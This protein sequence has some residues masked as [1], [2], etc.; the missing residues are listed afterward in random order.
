[1][2][3]INRED[4]EYQVNLPYPEPQVEGRNRQYA[5]TLLRDYAGR[6]SELTAMLQYT[7]NSY[8]LKERNPEIAEIMKEI[9]E[10][11]KIHLDLLG[12]TILLLGLRPIYGSPRRYWS[13]NNVSYDLSLKEILENCIALETELIQNYRQQK[14]QIRDRYIDALLQ[15][16][17][18][19]DRL[20]RRTCRRLYR[21][22][23]GPLP[24]NQQDDDE[25]D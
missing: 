4:N 13:G 20:H 1:M 14:R 6:I 18:L 25:E 22:N 21:R 12:Q 23:I 3:E 15:R 17:I 7:Y 10:V 16:I 9:A 5:R 8:A 19:D 2:E 24:N 11:D